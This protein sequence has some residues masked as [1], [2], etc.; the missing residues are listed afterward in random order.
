MDHAVAPPPQDQLD[1]LD[2]LISL[3]RSRGADAVDAMIYDSVSLSLSQRLGKPE[4]LDRAESGDV[5]LRVFLGKRMAI[6]SSADRSRDVL[7]AL[8]DRAVA[9]AR[10]VPEDPHCGIADPDQLV[11]APPALDQFDP[12]EPDA[13]TLMAK[14]K[15]AED[16][17]LAVPGITNSEGAECSW[18]RSQVTL[19]A[20]NGF[21]G[22]Y[23][24]SRTSLSVQAVAGEGTGMEVDYDFSSTVYFN[25]LDDPTQIGRRAA[26]RALARL[27]ARKID[28]CRVPVVYDPRVS[29]SLIRHVVG[30]ISGTAIARG[31]SFLKDRMGERILPAGIDIIDD[32]HRAR[33]L[34]SKPFDAEGLAN[35]PMALVEDGVLK[36]WVLDLRSAR[37][38]GLSPTG[39]ASRGT[40]GPP[41]PSPT[42]LSLSPGTVSRDA[43]IKAVG[44]GLLITQMMGMTYSQTTG[45]YSRGASGF[46]I[47]NGEIAYPVCEVTVAGNLADMLKAI[48]VADDLRYKYGIDA[49][50]VRVDGM[51]G[52][53]P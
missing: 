35:G 20:S 50:T 51:T 36:S 38:L 8:V 47:E 2:Q 15:L 12:T 7:E 37:Q 52:A 45:D 23:R 18:G 41:G 10:A 28:S 19:A 33:G 30:A 34:R 24:N 39:H 5:G 4:A 46:W 42:N 6:V 40:S 29:N 25:D 13:D 44:S 11:A 14:A 3:A 48:T 27:G 49:P 1:L 43:L 9:M 31:T 21:V 53:G 32:P 17:A 16:T 26:E 22:S